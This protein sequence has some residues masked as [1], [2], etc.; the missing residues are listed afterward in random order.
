MA[1][2]IGK[3]RSIVRPVIALTLC[4]F[5]LTLLGVAGAPAPAAAFG[6]FSFGH[7]GGGFGGPG[8][9]MGRGMR[10]PMMTPRRGGT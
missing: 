6:G 9:G 3:L 1:R 10:G 5:A 8:M 2:P 4:G 7:M